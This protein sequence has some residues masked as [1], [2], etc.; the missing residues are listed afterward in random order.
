[1]AFSVDMLMQPCD[2]LRLPWSDTDQGAAWMNSPPHVSRCAYAMSVRYRL[3]GLGSF[4]VSNTVF[5][6]R[7]MMIMVPDDEGMLGR[8]RLTGIV[9]TT[10]PS[11]VTVI[12]FGEAVS[13][14][15]RISDGPMEQS[16]V[17]S[18]L[19]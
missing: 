15:E 3:A 10:W 14:T 13:S 11:F 5:A 17:E 1:L 2:T 19:P 9:L 7:S 4:I 12:T 6:R 8:P 18:R 16:R